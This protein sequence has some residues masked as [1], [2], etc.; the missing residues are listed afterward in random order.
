MANVATE[1]GWIMI[2]AHRMDPAGLYVIEE[3]DKAIRVKNDHCGRECW[4]PKSAIEPRKP[5]EPTYEN[6][7]SIRSWFYDKMSLRQQQ[8]LNLAE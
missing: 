1:N 6:E 2:M 4:L 7:Y 8:V 5:G 3:T